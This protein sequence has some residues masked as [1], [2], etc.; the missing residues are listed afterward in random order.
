ML[1]V[2]EV[3]QSSKPTITLED[4]TLAVSWDTRDSY[5]PLYWRIGDFSQ[6][7]IE[8]GIHEKN[9]KIISFNLVIADCVLSHAESPK[10]LENGTIPIHNGIPICDV[11][12]WHLDN[13]YKSHFIDEHEPFTVYIGSNRVSIILGNITAIHH[14]LR[15]N[16]V[17]FGISDKNEI[18]VV[19]FDEFSDLDI[20]KLKRIFHIK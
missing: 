1:T 6:S 14:G 4:L 20:E 19:E 10:L 7:L 17:T 12:R 16:K 5:V 9:N 11:S 18:R 13:S 15:T 3:S 8:I 2:K